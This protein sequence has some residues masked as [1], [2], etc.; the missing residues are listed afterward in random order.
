MGLLSATYQYLAYVHLKL[1]NVL[2]LVQILD[3]QSL[4]LILTLGISFSSA[5]YLEILDYLVMFK[6]S[7]MCKLLKL[8]EILPAEYFSSVGVLELV[9]V[10]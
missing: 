8:L 9:P 3:K 7:A 2:I 5:E 1:R 10:T 6:G 4:F